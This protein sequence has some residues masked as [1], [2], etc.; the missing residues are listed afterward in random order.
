MADESVRLGMQKEGLLE[1]PP[2]GADEG[3]R[4]CSVCCDVSD[5]LVRETKENHQAGYSSHEK[6]EK[7][8]GTRG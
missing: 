5:F 1:P 3:G 8:K 4:D 7:V 6:C 2:S